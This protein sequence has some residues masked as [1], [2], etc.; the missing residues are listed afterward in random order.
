ME[1]GLILERDVRLHQGWRALY[2]RGGS[3]AGR[4]QAVVANKGSIAER[5]A[6]IE[7]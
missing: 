4:G 7:S 1:F 2:A 6:I 3:I 5:S